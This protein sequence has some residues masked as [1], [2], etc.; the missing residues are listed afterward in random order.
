MRDEGL[1]CF[2]VI[3]GPSTCD[4]VNR[5]LHLSLKYMSDLKF[6]SSIV[7]GSISLIFCGRAPPRKERQC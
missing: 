7:R 6:P 2:K 4:A 3:C 5:G 1:G